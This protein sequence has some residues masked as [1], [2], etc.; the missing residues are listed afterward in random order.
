MFHK[1][2]NN[3]MNH[4]RLNQQIDFILEIDRLKA[5]FR[6][7]YLTDASRFES[8]AEHS[9]HIAVIAM[10]MAEHANEPDIDLLKVIRMLLIHDLVEI[11]AGDTFAYDRKAQT[12]KQAREQAAAERIFRLL[13]PDQAADFRALWEE[14]EAR[15]TP[16]ARFAEALDRFQPLLHNLY[17]RGKSWREHGVRKEQVIAFNSHMKQGASELW[18]FAAAGIEKAV[19]RGDLPE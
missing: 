2:F 10:V 19:E 17:T 3:D 12:G 18:D 4:R 13:P 5:V 14:L 8:S 16:E 9:W 1:F 11:D 6:R 15:H 7:T